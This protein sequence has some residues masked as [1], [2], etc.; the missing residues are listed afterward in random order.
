MKI[1]DFP[2][3]EAGL[4]LIRNLC[5]RKPDLKEGMLYFQAGNTH[6]FVGYHA[7]NGTVKVE[8]SFTATGESMQKCLEDIARR[9]LKKEGSTER[10]LQVLP[11]SEADLETFKNGL[12]YGEVSLDEEDAEIYF[13]CRAKPL[14]TSYKR[15]SGR[16]RIPDLGNNGRQKELESLKQDILARYNSRPAEQ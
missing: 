3:F 7:N 10:T 14:K 5:R 16:H 12:P 6:A 8:P 1:Y 11:F 2:Q 9:I 13:R 15:P 4:G